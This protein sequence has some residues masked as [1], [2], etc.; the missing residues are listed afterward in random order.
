MKHTRVV[1]QILGTGQR[2]WQCNRSL[3]NLDEHSDKVVLLI[4]GSG[5]PGAGPRQASLW[6]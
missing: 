2:L 4:F 1:A 3:D 5:A 6:R